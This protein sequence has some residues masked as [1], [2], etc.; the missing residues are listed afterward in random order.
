M[1]RQP[2]N[3]LVAMTAVVLATTQ[4]VT[5]AGTAASPGPID[6]IP[7][8]LTDYA[9]VGVPDFSAC[10]PEWSRP[11]AEANGP[12]QWTFSAPVALADALWW[13]DSRAEPQ[14]AAP[15]FVRDGHGL[16]TAYPAFG[17]P[18]DDHDTAN[19]G[20][21]IDD[22]AGRVNTDNRG[23][24]GNVRGTRW[25]D[26]VDGV[27]SYVATRR[28]KP[29]YAVATTLR[30]TGLWLRAQAD[31]SAGVV[32]LI[33]VWEQAGEGWR[34]IGGHYAALAGTDAAGEVVALAD[35]VYDQAVRPDNG[36]R[37]VPTDGAA[38][39]CRNA[40]RAHDDAGAVSHD[41]YDLFP[42]SGMPD[43]AWALAGYF[44]PET[45]GEGAAFAGQNPADHLADASGTWQRGTLIAVLD[46]AL[47]LQPRGGGSSVP[48]A[49]PPAATAPPTP[50][51]AQ[52]AEPTDAPTAPPTPTTGASPTRARPTPAPIGGR[53]QFDRLW[54][55]ALRNQSRRR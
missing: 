20:P 1:S 33:G 42:P 52:S 49:T 54:L 14:P 41:R 31:R 44:R 27:E 19:L 53:I 46:A 36:G 40:P 22:L 3:A 7:A 24:P 6:Y 18:R 39:S 26:F 5:S 25:E 29:G 16:V 43:A 9:P 38:H 13:L 50:T 55:P 23:A 48:T 17:P 2:R 35:P 32:V 15:P 30:P 51:T 8:D 11:A 47:A 34:R 45:F 12:G 28:L 37:F 10:R 21:L 4:I